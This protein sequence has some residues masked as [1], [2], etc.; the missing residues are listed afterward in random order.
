M[1]AANVCTADFMQRSRH[2]GLFRIHEG[3]TVEKLQTL[4]QFLRTVGLS[5]GGGDS[6]SPRDY[7]ALAAQMRPRPDHLLLQTMLL[8]SMQQAVYSPENVGHFG[9]AYDAYA[10]FTSPIR[11]YPDLM[12]HRVIKSLLRGGRHVPLPL[13]RRDDEPVTGAGRKR[14][15]KV[16]GDEAG[17]TDQEQLI[18]RWHQWGMRC[19]ANERRADEASRDVE[20][21]L[22]CMYMRERVGEQ[23][24][25]RIT[26]V[27][28]FGVFVTL[29][30]LHVEGMV[31]V[32][33]LGGEYFQY[34]ESGHEL[35]GERTGLRFRLT[36]PIDIQVS[37]V[38]LEARRMEF[39][40]V[41]RTDFRSF[42][43]ERARNASRDEGARV[44]PVLPLPPEVDPVART[45]PKRE[46]KATL[47]QAGAK[48]GKVAKSATAAR[49]G[50]AA[51]A[52]PAGRGARRGSAA[53]AGAKRRSRS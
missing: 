38:D 50:K 49:A 26:G 8:R 32:S 31:H 40:L 39:R 20:A 47:R 10:H 24:S 21:W 22:K 5:L 43:R 16:V 25:G 36:D 35:R 12:T 30:E 46:S 33:E 19:S 2:P 7:A 27:A 42:E 28:P 18:E 29:D 51:G 53:K 48:S 37:R 1:L 3:P 6:P 44:D 52:G 13:D 4:R 11:R 15:G 17:L 41:P 23:F 45:R 14:R 34:S 9:L